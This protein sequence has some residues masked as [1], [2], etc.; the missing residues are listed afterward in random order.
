MA[1]ANEF[2]VDIEFAAR[3]GGERS[4]ATLGAAHAAGQRAAVDELAQGRLRGRAAAGAPGRGAAGLRQLGGFD[5]GEPHHGSGDAD[6]VP[7]DGFGA[8]QQRFAATE[9]G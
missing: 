1:L 9:Y 3:A 7:A 6:E 2:A 5:A 8:P 4:A